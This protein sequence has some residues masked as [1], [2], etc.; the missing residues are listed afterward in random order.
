VTVKVTRTNHVVLHPRAECLGDNPD[1][2]VETNCSEEWDYGL[3]TLNLIKAHIK[4]RPTHQV[5]VIH[6]TRSLYQRDNR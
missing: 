3:N 5:V 2:D 4:A 6:E 1:P